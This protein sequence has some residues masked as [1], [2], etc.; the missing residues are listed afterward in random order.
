MENWKNPI[1]IKNLKSA[2]SANIDLLCMASFSFIIMEEGMKAMSAVI[3]DQKQ[4]DQ[5]KNKIKMGDI[6]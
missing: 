5:N 6:S 4:L 2:N 1:H 3:S